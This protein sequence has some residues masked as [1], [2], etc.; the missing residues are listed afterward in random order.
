MSGEKRILIEYDMEEEKKDAKPKVRLENKNTELHYDIYV[1]RGSL[2]VLREG[3][4]W[5]DPDFL[6]TYIKNSPVLIEAHL[7]PEDF[8]IFHPVTERYMNKS[9][10]ELITDITNLI[11]K[12]QN[13]ERN[14]L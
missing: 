9:K 12:N 13:L 8:N 6:Y 11:I 4:P 5:S 7:T 3:L 14:L 2:M 1:K 10:E